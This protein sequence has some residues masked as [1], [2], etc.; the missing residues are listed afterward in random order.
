MFVVLAAVFTWGHHWHNKPILLL[1]DNSTVCNVWLSTTSQDSE[2]M[3]YIRH[4]FLFSS[5][6]NI[7]LIIK[8]VPIEVNIDADLLSHL[9]VASFKNHHHTALTEPSPINQDIWHFS[10]QPRITFIHILLQLLHSQCTNWLSVIILCFALNNN[11]HRLPVTEFNIM[12]YVTLLAS[13]L[14]YKSIK[15]YLWYSVP[16]FNVLPPIHNLFYASTLLL[17]IW[18]SSHSRQQSFSCS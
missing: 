11:L 15:T 14:S 8:H 4:L 13:P 1:S 12:F 5:K 18:Y 3:Y 9:P 16:C 6:R 17:V 2:I 10:Y 7:N